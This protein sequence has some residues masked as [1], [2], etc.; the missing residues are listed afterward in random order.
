MG[1]RVG[2]ETVRKDI[3]RIA[4]DFQIGQ[5]MWNDEDAMALLAPERFAEWRAKVF[6]DRFSRPYETPPHQLAWFEVCWAL[7]SRHT[8]QAFLVSPWAIELLGLPDDLNEMIADNRLTLTIFLLGPPR[9]GK[10][11][12]A[13][14]FG[15]WVI[16]RRRATCLMLTVGPSTTTEMACRW[17]RDELV[18][19]ELLVEKWGPFQ[20]KPWR[21]TEF[22]VRHTGPRAKAPTVYGVGAGGAVLGRDADL[23]IVDDP[24]KIVKEDAE[25]PVG[26]VYDW[27]RSGVMSRREPETAMVCFGSHQNLTMGDVWTRFEDNQDRIAVG[28]TKLLWSKLKAHDVNKCDDPTSD[29]DEDHIRCMLWPAKRPWNYIQ[30]KRGE[31]S[32]DAMF[33]AVYNQVAR[34]FDTV[35]FPVEILQAFY[36]PVA[37]GDDGTRD[38]WMGETPGVLDRRR[39]WGEYPSVCC[40][41]PVLLCGGVDPAGG[42]KKQS[43]FSAMLFKAVCR[44]C[45][46]YYYVDFYSKKMAAAVVIDWIGKHVPKYPRLLSLMFEVNSM[47]GAIKDS[48]RAKKLS[49]KHGFRREEW[50]TDEKKWDDEVGVSNLSVPMREGMASIPAKTPA[51][52]KKGDELLQTFRRWPVRP[53]DL[54]MA[55]WFCT[56][57][58]DRAITR[59]TRG[60]KAHVMAGYDVPPHYQDQVLRVDLRHMRQRAVRPI[61]VYGP[62]PH[63]PYRIA[64]LQ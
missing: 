35:S 16:C 15:V 48:V 57:A 62:M 24:L 64:S 1:S 31:F 12:F 53:T 29:A 52:L 25:A 41:T 51:D 7:C 39:S 18:E 40:T 8:D 43:S 45:R 61:D 28:Y 6:L 17:I 30:G 10:T 58:L 59:A 22:S 42:K 37:R 36:E 21:A 3:N 14:H 2:W 47:Q 9:H 34:T 4:S 38:P 63:D 44:E 13:M 23:I 46:R 20:G 33:E 50:Y 55:D 32:D 27:M 5:A 54:A 60:A 19:N 26:S 56:L 49:I 11:E